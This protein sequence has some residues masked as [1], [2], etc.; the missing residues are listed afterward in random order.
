MRRRA[1]RPSAGARR[2]GTGGESARRKVWGP[3]GA[4]HHATGTMHENTPFEHFQRRT[5]MRDCKPHRLPFGPKLS[6]YAPFAG[7][8]PSIRRV[9]RIYLS[10]AFKPK[11]SSRR[12]IEAPP[13]PW[14]R[15]ER[16]A[17]AS[18]GKGTF[19]ARLTPRDNAEVPPSNI[20]PAGHTHIGSAHA[21]VFFWAKNL[22]IRA[23][24]G[25]VV[26]A[27]MLLLG[28][29]GETSSCRSLTRTAW[30]F[31]AR[32]LRLTTLGRRSTSQRGAGLCRLAGRR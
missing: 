22:P 31:S 9:S 11:S 24:H 8:T 23:I 4:R 28:S 19:R 27:P 16:A 5:P 29:N 13:A 25:N 10:D 2:K 12:I 7:M 17:G 26:C 32:S 18:A 1:A 3:L 30:S 21:L 14:R 15:K 6:R 20:V